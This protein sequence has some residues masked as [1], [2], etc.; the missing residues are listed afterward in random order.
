MIN[1]F[2]FLLNNLILDF[3]IITPSICKN[4]S[5]ILIDLSNNNLSKTIGLL[6][7]KILSCHCEKRNEIVWMYSL[8]GEKPPEDLSLRGTHIL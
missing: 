7:G 3:E 6:I 5:L 4:S 8:R 2:N 1:L